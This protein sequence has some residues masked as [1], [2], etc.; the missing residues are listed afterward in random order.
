[1]I[2]IVAHKGNAF[3]MFIVLKADVPIGNGVVIYPRKF[4]IVPFIV[5]RHIL[6]EKL[7]AL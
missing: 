2:C 1:M 3:N 5:H 7:Y 6:F 4:Y